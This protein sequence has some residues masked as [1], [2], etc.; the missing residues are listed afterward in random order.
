[1]KFLTLFFCTIPLTWAQLATQS[2]FFGPIVSEVDCALFN[3][4]P[5]MNMARAKAVYKRTTNGS[6][7]PWRITGEKSSG[8]FPVDDCYK[9]LTDPRKMIL[10]SIESDYGKLK[11]FPR[12]PGWMLLKVAR[13]PNS[14]AAV[15]PHI[16]TF[17][18]DNSFESVVFS[19]A[20][21]EVGSEANYSPDHI[22]QMLTQ[23][24]SIEV[25]APRFIQLNSALISR[26]PKET[27]K[28]LSNSTQAGIIVYQEN[29]STDSNMIDGQE[30]ASRLGVES[31]AVLFDVGV[32]LLQ[33]DDLSTSTVSHSTTAHSS[34]ERTTEEDI[35]TTEPTQHTTKVPS[36]AAFR[37]PPSGVCLVLVS[38]YIWLH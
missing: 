2:T 16:P 29:K 37:F 21:S 34:T 25:R 26:T 14:E 35:T 19:F 8:S 13:G 7:S 22:D 15:L 28:E 11:S 36:G 1:M 24:R 20:E 10:F 5:T 18:D 31:K 30:V 17:M 33:G 27:F 6:I 32:H 9:K 4:N 23:M 3:D 38:I 12:G